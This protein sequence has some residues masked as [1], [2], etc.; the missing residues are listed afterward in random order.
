MVLPDSGIIS[1]AA[2]ACLTAVEAITEIVILFC[3]LVFLSRDVFL[4]SLVK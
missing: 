2:S 3:L 4:Y 1:K